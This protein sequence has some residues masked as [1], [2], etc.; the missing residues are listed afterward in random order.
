VNTDTNADTRPNPFNAD[1]ARRTLAAIEA[2]LPHWRQSSWISK[3]DCGTAYCF[4]GWAV[5]LHDG[6]DPDEK[7]PIQYKAEEALGLDPWLAKPLFDGS[8][9]LGEL[10]EMVAQ[11]AAA[12]DESALEHIASDWGAGDDGDDDYEQDER[13]WDDW[14][15]Y[16]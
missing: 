14:D 16:A 2:D 10:R 5:K 8:N 9:T 12:E 15:V 6:T 11:Y 7:T 1:L 4:A 3:T 13:D